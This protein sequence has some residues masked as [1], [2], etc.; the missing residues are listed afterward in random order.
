[1][2]PQ[3]PPV[4]LKQ[5]PDDFL[6][7]EVLRPMDAGS[8]TYR[9]YRLTKTGVDT[10]EAARALSRVWK[11]PRGDISF[12]GLKDR[13]ARTVQ[14]VAIRK[15]PDQTHNEP[16]F[17]IV[18][19]GRLDRALRPG[20]L[21]ENRFKLRVRDLSKEEGERVAARVRDVAEHGFANYYDDQRFGSARGT[22]GLLVGEAL[23]TGDVE[24][25]L[26]LALASPSAAD[27]GRVKVVR[28]LLSRRWGQWGELARALPPSPEKKVIAAL[29]AGGSFEEAYGRIDRDL[30]SLH[31]SALQA[32]IFN[33]GLRNTIGSGPAHT[34]MVGAYVFYDGAPGSWGEERVPL[35]EAR[36]EPHAI[37]DAAL[38]ARGI[39]RDMLVDHALRRGLRGLV[40]HPTNLVVQ[41]PQRDDRNKGRTMVGL[42]FGLGSGSYATMLIKRITYDL[43]PTE[44]SRR[45]RT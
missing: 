33:D 38:A 1:M 40:T 31:L 8:G 11:V 36:A 32:A 20:D 14:A 23:V 5:I 16:R 35:A 4:K 28:Q 25:A 15:G 42:S 7:E 19:T 27:R 9:L 10:L 26:R 30:R 2:P 18:P 22:S 39:D 44:R 13:H 3:V 45:R 21:L 37:L 43:K 6:V 29:A 24:G 12:A 41:R 34:G 17:Q